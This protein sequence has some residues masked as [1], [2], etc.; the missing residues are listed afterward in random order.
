VIFK[1][2]LAEPTR[3]DFS[4]RI[5][6]IVAPIGKGQRALIVDGVDL[7][8]REVALAVLRAPDRPLDGVAG[9]QAEAAPL[10]PTQRFKLELAEP[11]RKDFSPRIIDIVAPIGNGPSTVSPV[12]RPKRRIC[13][14][15][16]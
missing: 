14:G 2:E 10:F 4:P 3:K 8:Q 5:I 11:T 7:E 12:R 16:M 13:V 1:L 9:A 6:D 15:E